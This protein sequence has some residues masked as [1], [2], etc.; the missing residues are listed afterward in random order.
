MKFCKYNKS[1]NFKQSNFTE[2]GQLS[3][4][5]SKYDSKVDPTEEVNFVDTIKFLDEEE[6]DL[7]VIAD[8]EDH[9]ICKPTAYL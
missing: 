8:I 7:D 9:L 1:V 5:D 4:E 6:S 2:S 3:D